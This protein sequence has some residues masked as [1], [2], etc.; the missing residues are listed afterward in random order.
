MCHQWWFWKDEKG[1]TA[2]QL[3]EA[4]NV[5]SMPL[6]FYLNYKYRLFFFSVSSMSVYM[7]VFF[8]SQKIQMNVT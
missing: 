4:E 7:C 5:S 8:K 1:P 2:G 3:S 6:L